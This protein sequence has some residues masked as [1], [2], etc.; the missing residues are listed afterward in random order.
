MPVQ[1]WLWNA[2][3]HVERQEFPS[4]MPFLNRVDAL[5]QAIKGSHTGLM[6]YAHGP[7]DWTYLSMGYKGQQHRTFNFHLAAEKANTGDFI[8]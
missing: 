7:L 4:V 2:G 8:V 6:V 1:R 5:L 3:N